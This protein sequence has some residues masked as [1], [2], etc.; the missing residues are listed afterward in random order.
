MPQTDAKY[1]TGWQQHYRREA[2]R[3]IV[4]ILVITLLM[5]SPLM[6]DPK[7]KPHPKYKWLLCELNLVPVKWCNRSK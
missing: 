2:V 1:T 5:A 3:K 4:L 7:D 6:A